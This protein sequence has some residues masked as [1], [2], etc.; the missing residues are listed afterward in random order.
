MPSAI[1][2]YRGGALWVNVLAILYPPLSSQQTGGMIDATPASE[3]AI[4]T[5]LG[6]AS[7][8]E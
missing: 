7:L 5:H 4:A 2:I 3:N 6:L 8:V 1:F